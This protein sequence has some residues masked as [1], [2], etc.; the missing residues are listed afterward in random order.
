MPAPDRMALVQRLTGAGPVTLRKAARRVG[1]DVRAVHL[2]V[3]MLL[4][5]GMLRKDEEGRSEFPYSGVRV[6]FML[7][8]AA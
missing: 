3:H 7:K 8:V 4:R 1:R 2:D 6:D 5:A